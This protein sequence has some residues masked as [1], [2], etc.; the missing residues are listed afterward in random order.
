MSIISYI[1]F[2]I[3]QIGNRKI[4]VTQNS[5]GHRFWLAAPKISAQIRPWVEVSCIK[6]EGQGK[7]SQRKTGKIQSPHLEPYRYLL[8]QRGNINTH[9]KKTRPTP[10]SPVRDLRIDLE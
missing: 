2:P 6:F 7:L 5:L 3:S 4:V 9:T 1:S 8:Q 10:I